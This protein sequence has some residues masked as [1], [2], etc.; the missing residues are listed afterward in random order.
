MNGVSADLA[1]GDQ[2]PGQRFI[3]VLVAGAR[4]F[5]S[6]Q[7]RCAVALDCGAGIVFG[8]AEIEITF[9]VGPRE[10]PGARGKAVDQ[11]RNLFQ[12]PR[13]KDKDIEFGSLAG[14][15]G[16]PG[17]H[18]SMLLEAAEARELNIL[19]DS[20]DLLRAGRPDGQECPSPHE[21]VP[22]VPRLQGS[23]NATSASP[24]DS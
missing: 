20:R 17:W 14:W 4:G 11:P 6:A 23:V 13:A 16:S 21:Y 3:A 22:H 7:E 2:R 8:E 24:S 18:T 5:E 12:L 19:R 9:G 10:S 1:E 15:F